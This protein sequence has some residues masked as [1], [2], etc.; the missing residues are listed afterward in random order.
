M[1]NLFYRGV[2]PESINNMDF[3]EMAEWNKWHERME[4]TTSKIWSD[5]K[6]G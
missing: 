5:K 6:N 1:G 2:D 3:F 4:K